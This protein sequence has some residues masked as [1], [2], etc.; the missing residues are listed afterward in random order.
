M[1]DRYSNIDLVFRNGLKE[2]EV[3]PPQDAWNGIAPS[4]AGKARRMTWLR[5]AAVAAITLTTGIIVYSLS[6][7]LS[8]SFNGPAITLN[9][10]SRPEGRYLPPI[11]NV[12]PASPIILA[13]SQIPSET[14]N[15]AFESNTYPVAYTIPD[16]LSLNRLSEPQVSLPAGKNRLFIMGNKIKSNPEIPKIITANADYYVPKDETIMPKRN[17]WTIGAMATPT[18]YS[19]FGTSNS[20]TQ[21]LISSESS[22]MSYTGGLSFAFNV[23]KRISLQMGL[24]YSSLNH[25]ID[26][27]NVYSGFRGLNLV[28]GSDN[29]TVMTANGIIASGNNDLFLSNGKSGDRVSS[30]FTSDVFDP[31]KSGLNYV[32]SSVYQNFNYLEVPFMVRYKVIDKTLGMN[33]MGGISYNQLLNNSAY[34]VADGNRYFIGNTEGM[35]PITLSS[36]LGIGMEYNLSKKLS[37]NLEPTFRYYFTPMS[38]QGGSSLHPFTFGVFSGFSYK[39]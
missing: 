20:A 21:N 14:T 25:E 9:Q 13:S 26:G 34:A 5:A 3:L 36:S 12:K 35:Y 17:R 30:V 7:A 11:E 32:S 29:F 2:F 15:D 39:F 6:H 38:G 18:Y 24:Y 31:S 19:M 33:V 23:N 16:A 37:L 22:A 1:V 10:E 4:I 8:A 28:K 27:V